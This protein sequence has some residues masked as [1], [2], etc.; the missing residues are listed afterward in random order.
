LLASDESN[1]CGTGI[2]DPTH[3][4]S[5]GN[6]FHELGIR[7]KNSNWVK[8]GNWSK[9]RNWSEY[10]NSTKGRNGN[11]HSNWHSLHNNNHKCVYGKAKSVYKYRFKW[12]YLR[13]PYIITI[14]RV[15]K[16]LRCQHNN[17]MSGP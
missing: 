13:L 7:R 8:D 10:R 14:G 15:N 11:E 17:G 16:G 5:E 1:D 2:R 3:H 12:N 9:S 6:C 4:S